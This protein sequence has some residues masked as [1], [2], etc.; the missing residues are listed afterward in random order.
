MPQGTGV[1]LDTWDV[2]IG[3]PVDVVMGLEMVGQP[4][5]I[6]EAKLSEQA[7]ERGYV[8][9]FGKQQIIAVRILKVLG[10]DIQPS[11]VK[12]GQDIDTGERS[13]DEAAPI[14]SHLDDMSAHPVRPFLEDLLLVFRH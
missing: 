9:A 5:G 11:A 14:G 3:M 7:I 1:E 8:M 2:A 6:D 13:A 12:I 4:F 10:I